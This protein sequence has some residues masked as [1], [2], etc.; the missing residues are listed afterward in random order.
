MVLALGLL[1][2]GVPAAAQDV[3]FAVTADGWLLSLDTDTGHGTL[4]F[5]TGLDSF[6][7]LESD[8]LGHLY[9][10]AHERDLVSIDFNSET[11]SVIGTL[12]GADC[13][14]ALAWVDDQLYGSA[15]YTGGCRSETLIAIDPGTAAVTQIGP[16]GEDWIDIDGLAYSPG[17]VLY[18]TDIDIDDSHR[19]LLTVD[20]ATGEASMVSLI[21]ER[22]IG[23]DFDDDT[24]ELYGVTVP[25]GTGGPSD[26][27]RIDPQTGQV[28]LVGPTGF[29][30]VSGLAFARLTTS[31]RDS[32]LGTI[33]ALY[34]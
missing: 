27:V 24:G 11:S 13:V 22:V 19:A 25:S 10:I 31:T 12:D 17:G 15:D 14:E 34:R 1:V 8:P 4:L 9:G 33:K 21:Q 20:L 29:N 28:T 6:E 7:G 16:Y 5:Y 18:A 30:F 32:H 2:V 3:L 26:L 23:L